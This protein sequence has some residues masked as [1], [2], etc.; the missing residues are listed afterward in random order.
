MYEL[1]DAPIGALPT[2]ASPPAAAFGPLS[3][4]EFVGIVVGAGSALLLAAAVASC[5]L[6][7][8][9][10]RIHDREKAAEAEAQAEADQFHRAYYNQAYLTRFAG[11]GEQSP[12]TTVPMTPVRLRRNAAEKL[13]EAADGAVVG[14][15]VPGGGRRMDRSSSSASAFPSP[16]GTPSSAL[17]TPSPTN[18]RNV[19]PTNGKAAKAPARGA[20]GSGTPSA[21]HVSLVV[22]SPRDSRVVVRDQGSGGRGQEPQEPRVE[23]TVG[24][25]GSGS[26]SGLAGW[27]QMLGL[28]GSAQAAPAPVPISVS[29]A[30]ASNPG[31][32]DT[33]A[34]RRRTPG[35]P[36][37]LPVK[38]PSPIKTRRP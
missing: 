33:E 36:L 19:T 22:R 35:S 18:I 13:R 38:M 34:G 15:G 26:G 17:G 16:S 32:P 30:P 1:Q 31:S 29:A 6:V 27:A 2:P 9:S 25:E 5:L 12:A 10:R 4:P 7:R 14:G 37:P 28:F 23:E 24:S 20:G 21:R 8:R 11:S 3:K